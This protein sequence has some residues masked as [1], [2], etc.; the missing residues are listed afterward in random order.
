[1]SLVPS[2]TELLFD[3]GLEDQIVGVTK[4]CCHPKTKCRTK[5][6]VGG[7][8]TVKISTLEELRPDL[9]IANKEENDRH[10]LNQIMERFPT[11]VSDILTIEDALKNIQKI[12]LMTDASAE[13]GELVEEIEAGL[14]SVNGICNGSVAYF[15]W[16]NP[17][18]LAAKATYIDELM[19]LLGFENSSG[20]L[21][22]YPQLEVGEI[23]KQ[24]PEYIF[25]SSEP[26]PFKSK[27]QKEYEEL[28]PDS[29]V[30][31]VD[32]EMFSWYGSRMKLAVD[33]FAQ[34]A[35]KLN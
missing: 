28:F 35:Q 32:G 31:L 13:A 23:T 18:M 27:H 19:N 7:T 6:I 20:H 3:L 29:E 11:Y 25:L 26:F 5:T 10:N 15:I 8:K 1:M 16:Q 12:G 17:M 22:R 14:A 30:L 33:Y 2:L 24:K 34:L 9:I 21:T 4:F